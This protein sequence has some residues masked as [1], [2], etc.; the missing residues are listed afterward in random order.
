MQF[1]ALCKQYC[2]KYQTSKTAKLLGGKKVNEPYIP[3]K[4]SSFYKRISPKPFD[5]LDSNFPRKP[6]LLCPFNIFILLASSDSDKHIL[7]RQKV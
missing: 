5:E 2:R 6:K 3:C 7:M 4:I 1:S